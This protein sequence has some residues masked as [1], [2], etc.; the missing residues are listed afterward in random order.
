[1]SSTTFWLSLSLSTI[2]AMRLVGALRHSLMV[3]PLIRF[4]AW[5][6][7]ETALDKI[8][9]ERLEQVR[10]ARRIAPANVVHRINNAAPEEIAP[11][12]IGHRLGEIGIFLR[13]QPVHK[14]RAP[15]ALLGGLRRLAHRHFGVHVH[16]GP[17]ILH[18]AAVLQVNNLLP[19]NLHQVT[20][21]TAN[22]FLAQR[23][24]FDRHPR[25]IGAELV[26]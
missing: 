14:S 23:A 15:V 12:A 4:N 25:E 3:V 22:G 10:I 8:L 24:A 13:G 7:V 6:S 16:A 17:G 21:E 2:L 20:G 19:W 9:L 11:G 18:L 1:M 5:A 26:V